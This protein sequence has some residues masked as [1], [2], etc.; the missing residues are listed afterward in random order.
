M[1]PSDRRPVNEAQPTAAPDPS[2]TRGTLPPPEWTAAYG[3]PGPRR[4]TVAP[5]PLPRRTGARAEEAWLRAR[6]DEARAA[7]DPAAIREA[8]AAL[9]RWLA[10]RDR[11]LEEAVDL[12]G[13]ALQVAEDDELRRELAA[14]LESLGEAARA[15][16]ALRPIVS[17]RDVESGEGAYVLVRTGVLKARA[18]AAAGAVASFEAAMSVEPN[19]AL[20]AEMLGAVAAWDHDAASAR[21]SAE[22]YV[23]GA[24]RRAAQGQADAELEDLWRAVATDATS[25]L[26]AG[27][28]AAAL[29]RRDRRAVADEVWRAHARA[30]A[31]DPERAVR[32]HAGRR[33]AATVALDAARAL[34]AALDEG[35]DGAFEGEAAEALDA[36]LLD[37]GL[38]E[39]LAARLDVRARRAGSAQARAAQLVELA[40]L[41]AGPLADDGRASAAYAAALAADPACEDAAAGVRALPGEP[42]PARAEAPDGRTAAAAAWVQAS[43]A[44]DRRAQA[45][46]LERVAG[47]A[48]SP[49]KSV[50]LAVAADRYAAAGDVAAARRAAELATRADPNHVRAVATLAD[51]LLL[52]GRDRAAAAALERAIAVVGPRAVW[53]IA[54]AETLDGLGEEDLAI[55]W[56][57]RCVALRPGDRDAIERLLDRLVRAGDDARLG[58][59]LAWLL[60]QPHPVEW[61]AGPFART[62]RDLTGRAP[63]RAAVVARRALDVFGPKANPLR[64]AMLEAAAA[65]G[66]DAFASA[67]LERWLACGLQGS[68]R[69]DVL[70]RLADLRERMDDE[71]G[72]ARIVSRAVHEGVRHEALDRHL[73]WLAERSLGADAQLWRL[74]AQ[75]E[76]LAAE[77]DLEAVVWAWR[78]LGAALWDLA[79]DRVGAIDAWQRAARLA[80][81]RGHATMAF[82]LVDFAGAEFAF[83]YLGRLVETEPD[84]ATA[85]TIATGGARAALAIEQPKLA[86]DLVAR[87]LARCPSGAEALELAERSAARAG[88]HGPMSAIYELVAARALGRF[89]RRAAHYRAAR[90]FERHG[91]HGLALKHAAQAFYAVPAEGSSFQLLARAAERAGDRTQAVRTIEQVAEAAE[92]S[93]ARAAWLLRAASIAGEGEE[94]ARRRVD[95]LLRAV[96]AS[97]TVASIALLRDAARDLLRFGPEERDVLEMRMGRAA[98]AV[99]QRLDGPEGARAGVAFAVTAL[100]L[101]ADGDGALA[102]VERAFACDADVDEF[103]ELVPRASTLAQA[104]D[105]HTRAAA[106]LEAAEKPHANVGVPVLRLLAGVASALGDDPLRARACVAAALR[107]PDDDALVV[108]ADAAVRAAPDLAVRLGKRIFAGRRA[109]ALLAAARALA[110]E[111]S[112]A[113]GA[114]L[115]E[116]AVDLLDGEERAQAERELRAAWDAAGR[117]SETDVR[118]QREASSD[119]ASPSM[120]A[121]RWTEIAERRELRG[122][123]KGALRALLEAC[124]LDPDPLH[125]WSSL[126]RLAETTGDDAAR[127]TALERIIERVADDGRVAAVKRLARAHERRGDAEAASRTWQQV[128]VLDPDD[129]EADHAIEAAIVGQGQYE[130]LA[131]HLARRAER[132]GARSG[133]REMLRA[134]RLRRAVIL[135]QRLG[136]LQDACEELQTLLREWPDNAGALR[137]LADL[138]DRQAQPA[139]A[140]PLWRRAAAVEPDPIEREGLEMRAARS[141]LAAGDA[142]AALE[143]ARRVLAQRPTHPEA[144]A[145]RVEA[146]RVLGGDGELGDALDGLAADDTLDPRMR[147]DALVE[148]AQIAARAG[149]GAGAVG[150]AQ[151]AA[152]AAPDRATPQLLARGLEYR[153]RGAGSPDEARRT[154]DDLACIREPMAADDEALRAF[155]VAEA[156]DVVQGSGAGMGELQ[157]AHQ[158]IGDHPLLALGMA[159]R[160]VA[161]DRHAAAVE[162]YRAAVAGSL[163]GLRGPGAVA[164]AAADAALRAGRTEDAAHFLDVAEQHEDA[165]MPAMSRRAR[166]AGLRQSG[167][168]APSPSAPALA[169]APGASPAPPPGATLR[170]AAPNLSAPTVAP[171]AGAPARIDELEAALRAAGTSGE[172]A[173]A[174]LAL[175]RAH[176]ARGDSRAGEPLLWEALADGLVEAGDAL[177]PVLATSPERARDL[178]RVRRQQVGLEPGDLGRLEALAQAALADGDRVYARAVEHVLR[179]FDPA[180]G[181]LPPPPLSAQTEQP[182]LLALLV[183]PS[184]DAMGE[185]LALLWEGAMQLFVRDAASYGITGVERVVPGP[186]S[187]I[188]RVYEAA[189]R[190]LDAPRVPLFAPR[191]STGAPIAH[192][193]L[194]A[195]PAVIL[196]GDVRED[197]PELRFA[198]GRGMATALPQNVLRLGLPPAEGR[199]LLDALRA[200]FGPPELGRHLESRAAQL[201]ESFWQIVPA[202]TQRR[203]QEL[204]GTTASV[205][206]DELV[207]RAHQSGR[208]VGMFLAGDFAY[209]ARALLVEASTRIAEPP[210]PA[211]LRALCEQS[212]ALADLLRLAVSPEYANAR[213]HVPPSPE[214][215]GTGSSSG[216]FSL[217]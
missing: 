128:L 11:D 86:F 73:G 197:T 64:E 121:D 141:L 88:E 145:L 3:G 42:K 55:G 191:S 40:R 1:I 182:G 192:V 167:R 75:A 146:A 79:E 130:A 61:L 84:A 114:P 93:T 207:E 28:L 14:W 159:E 186:T 12:A 161:Q 23:E 125:R 209:A 95:V 132:L 94:G 7:G 113:E 91:E 13:S 195:L 169:A 30:V 82:D 152:A 147:G 163:L 174:R 72:E 129:E 8:C 149:D 215:R 22:A 99:T 97:P 26:A 138:L 76:R 102:S 208:R 19:D 50:L 142:P 112:H 118:V 171:S 110:A 21:T 117:G 38:L 5:Q 140:A 123:F 9:A 60:S 45:V 101:F 4:P 136:R 172:R 31:G 34:G 126:E 74:R 165:R 6:V 33:A 80:P 69:V 168:G 87:G 103:A 108:D 212:P 25:E 181:P 67:V 41:Y 204:L 127:V 36:L 16:G 131:D 201:A 106:L 175:G 151:Q 10:S 157:A 184:M 29:E 18:G 107:D 156:L 203:L 190:A 183:R 196:A 185:A 116:R 173:R 187:T 90:F 120:R 100:D 39:V 59:V 111:G 216:R 122:D 160:L 154:L 96:V 2:S 27:A 104:R 115:F 105:A 53:C 148:A 164:I 134:V 58:D 68:E 44:G 211:T 52:G 176:V 24:R 119:A 83:E 70:V 178:V 214:P 77:G 62:L 54:L 189:M 47:A 51:V 98:R 135:E 193:A 180:A 143:H 198:L 199:A 35:L 15:A 43:L 144:L 78:D 179:A 177:V 206:Y 137:Y 202:R 32:V 89:G 46:A 63:D 139:H 71:E 205:E 56:S 85:A 170:A 155:L 188:A 65:A 66:D 109:G 37:L 213:W 48:A 133:A 57:Q 162:C 124:K 200:A 49:A 194:L 150:R 217:F 92:P 17:M 81:S 210:T 20:P 153:L 166:L 158:A